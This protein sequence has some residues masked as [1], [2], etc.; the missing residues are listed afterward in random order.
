MRSFSHITAAPSSKGRSPCNKPA[1]HL[2]SFQVYAYNVSLVFC[3]KDICSTRAR[4]NKYVSSAATPVKCNISCTQRN[5]IST[6]PS[7]GETAM[8]ANRQAARPHYYISNYTQ[9][10]RACL[11]F[12]QVY[13]ESYFRGYFSIFV[14]SI[15]DYVTSQ[16]RKTDRKETQNNLKNL[17]LRKI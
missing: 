5:I 6:S 1:D 10:L 14:R 13:F 8:G 12:A 16:N 7:R 4:C 2:F 3:H 9:R 11:N 15:A 17:K